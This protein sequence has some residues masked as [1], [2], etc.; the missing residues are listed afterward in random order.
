MAQI[1]SHGTGSAGSTTADN[2][3]AR[4]VVDRI[5]LV[6]R[7]HVP[8]GGVANIRACVRNTQSERSLATVGVAHEGGARIGLECEVAPQVG[9]WVPVEVE[10]LADR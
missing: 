8:A 7:D 2:H 9:E 3:S 10:R 1:V 6:A 5:A 4:P